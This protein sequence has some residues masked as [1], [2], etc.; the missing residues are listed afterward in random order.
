MG[1]KAQCTRVAWQRVK[2]HNILAA[3]FTNGFVGVWN[4]DTTSPLLKQ[5]DS[6]LPFQ[7][8]QA[9]HTAITGRCSQKNLKKNTNKILIA[10]R[11]TW[12][13]F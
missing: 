2:P 4:L 10:Q 11:A 9:H 8:F 5:D 13:F 12:K 1:D 7:V 6:L 3:S